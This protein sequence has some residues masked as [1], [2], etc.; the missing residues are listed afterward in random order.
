MTDQKKGFSLPWPGQG[1]VP[2]ALED[3]SRRAFAAYNEAGALASEMAQSVLARQQRIIDGEFRRFVERVH[4]AGQVKSGVQLLENEAR[5]LRES[6][7]TTTSE[8][9][10][11][12]EVL[13]NGNRKM[14]DLWLRCFDVGGEEKK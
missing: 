12:N 5:A 7:E 14:L 10:A 11:I 13:L 9:R 8:M 3:A 1:A 4:D 2:Q 6:I